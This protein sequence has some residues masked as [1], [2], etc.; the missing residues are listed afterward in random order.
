[1]KNRHH[2]KQTAGLST[3]LQWTIRQGREMLPNLKGK[4]HQ[5]GNS[6]ICR[7]T[8]FME[9]LAKKRSKCLKQIVLYWPEEKHA[10]ITV[11]HQ[12]NCKDFVSGPIEDSTTEGT[13]KGTALPLQLKSFP[14][15]QQHPALSSLQIKCLLNK[16]NWKTK[17]CKYIAQKTYR[18]NT[19][20]IEHMNNRFP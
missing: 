9:M 17:R 2:T 10:H 7:K 14:W 5:V 11:S 1:M 12:G 8:P 13:R 4:R 15:S 16:V 6:T 3:V 18:T 20:V 19:G